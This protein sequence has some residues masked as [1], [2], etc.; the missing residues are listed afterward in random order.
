MSKRFSFPSSAAVFDWISSFPNVERG[1]SPGGPLQPASFDLHR[2]QVLAELAGNPERSA[3]SIHIAGSKGKGS[4][5]GMIAS[6]LE[7]AGIKAARYMSPHVTDYR[8]RICLGNNFFDESLYID[9]GNE[10]KTLLTEVKKGNTAFASAFAAGGEPTVFELL[11]LYFFLCARRAGAGY[12]AVE[13]GLGGRLDSTNIV[14]PLISII[15]GIELEHTDYLGN[16]LTAIAGEK[17]GIIKKRKPLALAEQSPEVLDV[18][19]EKAAEMDAP[20]YY[21]PDYVRIENTKVHREG[22][23]FT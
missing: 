12:M 15:T 7:A 6:I 17:A 13:T 8:E 18:F 19:R 10:L 2:M 1:R 22:T 16:T 11:T 5:T 20:L 21:F 14:D 3:E 9:G 23:N 4:V